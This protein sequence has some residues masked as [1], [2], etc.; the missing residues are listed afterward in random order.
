MINIYNI[1]M[2]WIFFFFFLWMIDYYKNIKKI[3]KNYPNKDVLLASPMLSRIYLD[4]FFITNKKITFSFCLLYIFFIIGIFIIL[5]FFI[6]GQI[7]IIPI[8]DNYEPIIN[9]F[10]IYICMC[11]TI[12][13]YKIVIQQLFL[14][15]INKMYLYLISKNNYNY[16]NDKIQIRWCKFIT[17]LIMILFTRIS[18]LT[19]KKDLYP[20]S[21]WTFD[22]AMKME[23]VHDEDEVSEY[24]FISHNKICLTFGYIAMFFV[25]KFYVIKLLFQLI[26]SIAKFF[27]DYID[28]FIRIVPTVTLICVGLYELYQ[29]T[30]DN[31]YYALF[32]YLI[33][34]IKRDYC[35]FIANRSVEDRILSNYFY[36]NS[37]DYNIQRLYF[38]SNEVLSM[39]NTFNVDAPQNYSFNFYRRKIIENSFNNF[40]KKYYDNN[41]N[42]LIRYYCLLTAI[43]L[44]FIATFSDNYIFIIGNNMLIIT[45][46]YVFIGLLVIIIF[47]FFK[48]YKKLFYIFTIMHG[49]FLGY[50]ILYPQLFLLNDEII[51]QFF[52][53]KIN[54]I[55]TDHEK[56]MYIYNYYDHLIS[57]LPI[58]SIYIDNMRFLLRQ[59]D[60][61]AFVSNTT[62]IQ[63]L[64]YIIKI[65]ICNMVDKALFPSTII[66]PSNNE[67]LSLIKI[68]LGIGV[69]ISLIQYYHNFFF[70]II[71]A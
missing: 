18:N 7:I 22:E 5:R 47:T 51:I 4:Q 28:N 68:I 6:L 63:D 34:K 21:T 66:S 39:E 54:I 57:S 2:I 31:I 3:I 70:L 29:K 40:Q 11:I 64:Q 38:F 33:I 65:F 13:L 55:L 37:I 32:I 42:N 12:F 30:F 58:S 26:G 14:E 48:V 1:F 67:F 16:F 15:E 45:W 8:V 44:T 56:V 36:N 10:L 20:T 53:V 24:H 71:Q 60:W 9:G 50:I 43:I 46:S 23:Y 59:I 27:Y 25:K 61:A 35:T 19:Y 52:I 62:S 69:T 41:T 17:G 49:I